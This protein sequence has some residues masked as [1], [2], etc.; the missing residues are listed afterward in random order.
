MAK[1][2]PQT[3]GGRIRAKD[4]PALAPISPAANRYTVQNAVQPKHGETAYE[5]QTK[6]QCNAIFAAAADT[7]SQT[8]TG[9]KRLISTFQKCLK[10]L[11]KFHQ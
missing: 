4:P 5:R 8:Q 1:P 10:P 3:V 9:L 7:A 11:R 6:A 2:V